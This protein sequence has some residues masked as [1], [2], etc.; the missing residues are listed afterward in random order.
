MW[1]HAPEIGEF[2]IS[3]DDTAEYIDAAGALRPASM[4]I[5]YFHR[6]Y[7]EYTGAEGASR[8]ENRRIIYFHR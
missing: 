6:R 8:P 4:S 3:I 1:L 5:I 7:A 2:V